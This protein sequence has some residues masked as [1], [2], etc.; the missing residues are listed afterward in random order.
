[1]KKRIVALLLV[2]MFVFVGMSYAAVE[3]V[4]VIVNGREVKGDVPAQILN[5]R[6]MTPARVVA[7]ALGAKVDWDGVTRTVTITKP[8]SGPVTMWEWNTLGIYNAI[9]D[10]YDVLEMATEE[11][12]NADSYRNLALFYMKFSGNANFQDLQDSY[13][14]IDM[15]QKIID[16]SN[17]YIDFINSFSSD[18][19]KIPLS[20]INVIVGE[21]REAKS[22]LNSFI[23]KDR[24]VK[25]YLTK[26][27]N[28]N[29]LQDGKKAIEE[30]KALLV[31][32]SALKRDITAK[33]EKYRKLRSDYMT[34]LS[35]R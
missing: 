28:S 23:D 30:S 13:K 4:E 29:D 10:F 25:D 2:A 3:T 15:L 18:S 1:V 12:G 27:F 21:M 16:A 6:T 35:T 26:Y 33:K 17:D 22:S 5:G 8:P 7:E 20:D 34:D 14:T 19:T 11:L 32:V 9:F 31:E 24:T